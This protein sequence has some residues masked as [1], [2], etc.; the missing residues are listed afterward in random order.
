MKALLILVTVI[1]LCGCNS[2]PASPPTAEGRLSVKT[3]VL[4]QARPFDFDIL[5]AAAAYPDRTTRYLDKT[6]NMV[7]P[8]YGDPLL[9]E[10]VAALPDIRRPWTFGKIHAEYQQE[11]DVGR[12]THLI[13][14][15]AASR[16]PRAAI[17]LHE[18]LGHASLEMRMA[19]L[20]GLWDHFIQVNGPWGGGA[21]QMFED[22]TKWWKEYE[23]QIRRAA[24]AR[25]ER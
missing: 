13:R 7:A 17:L 24:N 20:K 19:A 8:T 3:P 25:A 4:D 11:A 2:R 9:D 12:R 10:A 15:M 16:D 6:G 1:G 22:E 21:E 5:T 23:S 14:V 18:L